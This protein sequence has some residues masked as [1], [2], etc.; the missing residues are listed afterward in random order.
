MDLICLD[1]RT[2]NGYMAGVP[3][4]HGATTVH[5]HRIVHD[6]IFLDKKN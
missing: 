2:I 5:A 1:N 6:F 4:M 3:L